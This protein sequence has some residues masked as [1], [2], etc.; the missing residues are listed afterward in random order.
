[1]KD[2]KEKLKTD[3]EDAQLKLTQA[4]HRVQVLENQKKFLTK[5]ENRQRTHHLCNMGGAV[6][7]ISKDAD[8]LTKTEFFLL[9]EQIFLCQQCRI[10]FQKQKE[11]MTKEER[12]NGVI[13]FP[14]RSGE[15]K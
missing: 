13:L 6:Q 9:M 11:N 10:W 5:K 4:E 8:A 14:C 7:N 12:F 2:E 1:M 3:L 15:T